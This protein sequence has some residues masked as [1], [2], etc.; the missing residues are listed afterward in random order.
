ML[1]GFIVFASYWPCASA[2]RG[3]CRQCLASAFGT[4]GAVLTPHLYFPRVYRLS[5]SLLPRSDPSA[6]RRREKADT[7]ALR[8]HELVFAKFRL[9]EPCVRSL[10]ERYSSGAIRFS[11]RYH[12]VKDSFLL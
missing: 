1:D 6:F 3:S 12:L 9:P 2:P 5:V 10:R 8:A 7:L 11:F 4:V